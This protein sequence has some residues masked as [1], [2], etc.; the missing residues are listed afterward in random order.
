MPAT[1]HAALPPQRIAALADDLLRAFEHGAPIAPLSERHPAMTVDDAYAVQRALVA[2]HEAAGRTVAGHKIGLTSK[3]MQRQ[4]GVDT[5]DFGVLLDSLVFPSG[6]RLDPSALRMIAPRLE[7]ELGFVLREPLGAPDVTSAD[8]LAAT[9]GIVPVF[10]VIDSRVADWRI[11]LVDT[12]AD[13]A[14][15]FGAV[16]GAPVDPAQAAAPADVELTFLRDG[17]EL[18]RATGDAVMGDPAEAVAWLARTLH[19]FGGRL[20]AGVPI[21]SGS[22]TAAVPLES[23]RYEARCSGGLGAVEVTVG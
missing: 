1:S 7:P 5:P 14:S 4:V 11:A 17:E 3:A 18:D 10:E 23:G 9:A 19:G 2:G 8:V 21:L 16:L 6:A 15:G 13:N 12:I 20:P 22:F